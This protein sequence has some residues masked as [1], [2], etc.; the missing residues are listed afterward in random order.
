MAKRNSNTSV[1]HP[2]VILFL[3]LIPLISAINYYL[4]YSNIKFDGFLF[5]TFT[6]DTLQGYIAWL[7]V[8]KL[9]FWFDK[10]IPY[11]KGILKRMTVQ[12]AATATVGLT[13]I[14]ILT[15][16]VSFI[17]KGEFAPLHFYTTD[18]FIIG[19]WFFFINA[20]YLGLFYY[21]QWQETERRVFAEKKLKD[22]GFLV[23]VG[24]KEMKLDFNNLIGFCVDTDYT[25]TQNESGDKF[26]LDDSLEKIE[27]KLPQDDFFRLN[28]K[29]I[30]NR[31]LISGFKRIENGKILVSL[32][33]NKFLPSEISVSRTKAPLFKRWFRPR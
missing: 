32:L 26:Y 12:L 27:Q 30:V 33:E 22:E 1:Y 20:I 21:N 14:T 15:E 18:L 17:A 29:Y 24:K 4:T 25:V 13:I 16:I 9:I 5:L 11:E 7:A 31:N 8:R 6:I 23:K 19:I 10:K 28:R 3:I 2:D